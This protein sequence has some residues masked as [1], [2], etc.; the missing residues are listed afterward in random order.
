M[1]SEAGLRLSQKR[2]RKKTPMAT[3]KRWYQRSQRI[4][5]WASTLPLSVVSPGS[6]ADMLHASFRQ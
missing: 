2:V 6:R 1:I 3:T 4:K 5:N